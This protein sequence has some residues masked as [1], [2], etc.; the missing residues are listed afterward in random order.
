MRWL[1]F[2]LSTF[3]FAVT[4]PATAQRSE[5][6]VLI[7]PER[8][9]AFDPFASPARLSPRLKGNIGVDEFLHPNAAFVVSEEVADRNTVRVHWTITDGYY[10]YRDKFKF[11]VKDGK[12]VTLGT[13]TLPSG[14]IK[15]DEFFG[16]VEIF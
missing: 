6:P 14:K 1:A 7:Q 5:S 11:A 12:S 10:L 8:G 2:L 16:R 4:G 15:E 9:Q 13:V 3:L